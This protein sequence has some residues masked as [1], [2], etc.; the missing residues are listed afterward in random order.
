MTAADA[1]ETAVAR[2]RERQA[3]DMAQ[4]ADLYCTMGRAL[5]A[6]RVGHMTEAGVALEAASDLEYT[7]LGDVEEL[8]PAFD[9]LNREGDDG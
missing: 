8:L 6:A 9:V 1:I 7:L 3:A 4:W 2:L 5:Q